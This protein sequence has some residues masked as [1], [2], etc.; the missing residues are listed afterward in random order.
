MAL[1]NLYYPPSFVSL[2]PDPRPGQNLWLVKLWLCASALA[3]WEQRDQITALS[4]TSVMG[5]VPDRKCGCCFF[6]LMY[7]DYSFLWISRFPLFEEL[8]ELLSQ[9]WPLSFYF[10][11]PTYHVIKVVV[12]VLWVWQKSNGHNSVLVLVLCWLS[13]S[14]VWLRFIILIFLIFLPAHQCTWKRFK[15]I[16]S[17]ILSVCISCIYILIHGEIGFRTS[18][19]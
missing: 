5:N 18:F 16:V 9:P 14:L 2:S 8:G 7:F 6:Y 12:K 3:S 19:L 4:L 15:D 11:P 17:T 13:R 1:Q 10:F